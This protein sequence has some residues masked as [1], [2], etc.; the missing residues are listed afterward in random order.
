MADEKN[1]EKKIMSSAVYENMLYV[2]MQCLPEFFRKCLRVLKLSRR[3]TKTEFF[4]ISFVSAAGIVI[5]GFLGFII[6]LIFL[7]LLP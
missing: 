7:Y 3:P 2:S 4:K 1:T 5:I 6:Y